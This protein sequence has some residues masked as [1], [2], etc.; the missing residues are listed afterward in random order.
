M[1]GPSMRQHQIQRG[2][3]S[4]QQVQY[5]KML[6]LPTMALEQAIK[7]E[8]ERNI[9]LEE[10]HEEETEQVEEEPATDEKEEAEKE[11]EYDIEDF[12]NDEQGHKVSSGTSSNEERDEIPVPETITLYES[13]LS[14]FYLLPI[15][16]E[17]TIIGEEIIGNLSEDGYLRRPLEKIAQDLTLSTNG[18]PIT[19]EK[20]ESVL[21]RIQKLDPPGIGSR[22]LRECLLVQMEISTA[23]PQIKEL[24]IRILTDHW[25]AFSKKHYEELAGSLDISLDQLKCILHVIQHLNPKPG[26]GIFSP[27]QNYL[28]PDFIVTQ[29]E[30]GDFIISLNDRSIPPL[31]INRGYREMMSK[32]KNNGVSREAKDYIRQDFEKAKWFIN[33]LHQRR[34]TMQRV[35][36]TILDKQK[37]FFES[38]K[39]L[40]PLIYKDIAE[41][42]G[43]DISTIS[44]V[45]S[46]KAVQT[47]Y[48]T[49]E[50]RHFFSDK[51][52]SDDGE[53]VS[54]K[55]VKLL[56]KKLIDAEDKMKPYSDDKLKQML[57]AKGLN[58]AR[59]TV[60][61]YRE[62]MDIPVA[63]LRREL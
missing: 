25:G 38:G 36:E 62:Q 41:I 39:G 61:K 58:I 14:Q 4:P 27:Q 28:N 23:D 55:E 37:T 16:E 53:D 24:A 50:L 26:E 3:L 59:R 35:M 57:N 34:Q 54:N 63:R 56:L 43:M 15:S 30:N 42:I 20:A 12:L 18:P 52:E 29:E 60:A 32:R 7:A 44:R 5:L 19:V 10:G 8:I 46:K 1:I 17:E 11:D 45:V 33:S 31:R 40:K 2:T 6:Q 13:V 47:D 21:K 9:L 51:I 22:D 49:F 48:G